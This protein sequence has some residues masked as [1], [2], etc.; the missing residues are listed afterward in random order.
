MK[1]RDELEWLIVRTVPGAQ[2]G[3]NFWAG[4]AVDPTDWSKQTA[5][6]RIYEWKLDAPQPTDAELAVAW[7]ALEPAYRRERAAIDARAKR[8]ELLSKVDPLIEKAADTG[9]TVFER[10]LRQYRQAL[11]DVPA[12]AGFPSSIA[13][14]VAPAA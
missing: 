8:D 12:Q 2:H 5:D 6:A 11:R 9:N 7:S 3:V 13:W 10:S 4:H 1:H 14:P